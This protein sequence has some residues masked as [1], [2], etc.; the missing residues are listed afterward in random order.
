MSYAHGSRRALITGGA[1]FLGSHLCERLLA[2]DFEVVCLD[3]FLTGSAANIAY[4]LH[5][6]R[7]KAIE[8][9][10]NEVAEIPGEI[11][12]VL[13]FASPASPA[14]YLRLPIQTLQAGSSGTLRALE[15]A[16]AKQARF[17]LASSSEVYGNPLEHPQRE[18]YWG[19][20]N[21]IGLRSV[22]DEAKRFGEAL[23]TAYRNEFGV[24]T[25]IARIFNTYGPRM[26]TNDGRAV[27]T[28]ARQAIRGEPVTVTGDG[29]QTRSF[30]Y[31]DD[32]VDGVL[33]LAQS[34]YPGPVNIGSQEE[35]AISRL[36]TLITEIVSSP[37]PVHFV[38][39]PADDPEIRCPNTA[40]ANEVLGWSPKI[41]LES[42]LKKTLAWFADQ[43]AAEGQGA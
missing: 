25:A 11:G 41:S 13:H 22:Y 3:N 38:E 21:P 26:R 20:V 34:D 14:D 2:M 10:V 35:L 40:L 27:P 31:V 4:L 42:G 33:M 19:N 29:G 37:S 43:L 8:C 39:R 1:G 16:R 7:F 18:S 30:C 6:P 23:T 17:I 28:F 15:V 5:D 24:N 32:T 9:D 12:L 36:A